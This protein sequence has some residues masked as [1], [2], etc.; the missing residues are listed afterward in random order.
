MKRLPHAV[1]DLS[2]RYLKAQKIERLL[3]LSNYPKPIRLLEVG[4]GSGGIAHY[5]AAQGTD[6]YIV[7]EARE[8]ASGIASCAALYAFVFGAARLR[9]QTLERPGWLLNRAYR[10][11]SNRPDGRSA[12]HYGRGCCG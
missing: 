4:T 10:R 3:N 2:S 11:G 12:R 7:P 8:R 5:F 6:Q 9:N 1:S